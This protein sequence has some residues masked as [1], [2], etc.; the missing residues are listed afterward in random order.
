[1]TPEG[2]VKSRVRKLLSQYQ[3]MFTY[4]PVPGGFGRATIDVFGCYRGLF[5]AIET[6]AEGKKPTLRQTQELSN[7]ERAMGHVFVIAGEDDPALDRLKEFLDLLTERIDDNPD[8]SP[9]TVR[10]RTI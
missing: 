2:R 8:I 10:R 5:F 9:D 7:I 6:K 1:M 4:W 3:G